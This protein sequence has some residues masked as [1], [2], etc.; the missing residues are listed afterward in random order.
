MTAAMNIPENGGP[1]LGEEART[2]GGL[3]TGGEARTT[4]EQA[5]GREIRTSRAPGEHRD[6]LLGAEDAV[7]P[8]RRPEPGPIAV[9]PTAK[10]S[11]VQAVRGGGGEV[12]ALSAATRG[13][14]WLSDRE[15]DRLED[16]LATHPGIGWVQLPW[17]GVDAFA[18]LLRRFADSPLPVWTSAKGAYSE[19]VAEHAVALTLALLREL[20]QKA[21]SVSWAA[22][23]RGESLYG[24]R[25]VI[26]G[27]GGVA[28]AIMRLLSVFDAHVTIV[29]RSAGD[30]AGASQTVTSRELT[31]VLPDADVV[32]IAAAGTRDT[33]KLFGREA[34]AAMPEHAILVN[35]ARGSLVD[36]YAL[37]EA[38]R[39]GGIA[40]A[41]L[42]VTDPEPLPD[43]HPLW[44]EP[45]CIIT[46]H[47]AD[48]NEMTAPLLAARIRANVAAFVG[49]GGFVGI[50]DPA[51]GY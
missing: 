2:T 44:A 34:F 37:V 24:R 22:T 31:D 13:I 19:P 20:P 16:V 46:S 23:R 10:E 36:S 28:L 12:A 27:A 5:A 45:N 3:A 11:F 38:L 42:D 48:T 49:D 35:I 9:L 30:V 47:S 29:R 15:A 26:V 21:R 25:V 14:V 17:A 43:G 6:L 41:A 39:S 50:V 33:A 18:A 51:S 32:I 1:A 4:G 7:P 40:G 8:R